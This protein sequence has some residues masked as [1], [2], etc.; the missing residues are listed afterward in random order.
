MTHFGKLL[1]CSGGKLSRK[2]LLLVVQF[3]IFLEGVQ[4]SN[5]D[6]AYSYVDRRSFKYFEIKL[7]SDA[8]KKVD[9]EVK[10]V[11]G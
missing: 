3:T 11:K 7:N 4:T 1:S 8:E 10:D 9:V 6:I 5:C 2:T